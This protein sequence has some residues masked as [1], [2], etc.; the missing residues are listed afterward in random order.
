MIKVLRGSSLIELIVATGVMALVL[1]AIVAG[2][3]LSLK[4]GADSEYRTQAVK[5]AQEGM[6]VFRRE[7][8]L[9]GWDLFVNSL[10]ASTTYCLAT[11]PAPKVAFTPGLCS[12]SDVLIISSQEFFREA[13][14][15]IDETNPTDPLVKITVT[16]SWAADEKAKD[17]VLPQTFRKWD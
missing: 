7:R 4:I 2:L 6:E 9:L 13:T 8:T 3:T 10:R 16:V 1:T 5:R 12:S 17:V 14:V 15:S 11:L